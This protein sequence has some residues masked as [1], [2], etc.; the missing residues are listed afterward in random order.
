MVPLGPQM[1]RSRRPSRCA[2]VCAATTRTAGPSSH[3][4]DATR[5]CAGREMGVLGIFVTNCDLLAKLK[6]ISCGPALQ[7]RS[8]LP[9]CDFFVERPAIHS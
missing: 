4:A 7:A 2:M 9:K 3:A 6:R 5:T 1:L 8:K